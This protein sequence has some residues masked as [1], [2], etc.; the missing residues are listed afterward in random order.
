M[1][2]GVGPS[3]KQR[4]SGAGEAEHADGT[5]HTCFWP[6]TPAHLECGLES[7]CGS[8]GHGGLAEG[9]MCCGCGALGR[10]WRVGQ[11]GVEGWTV[12]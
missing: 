10:T 7:M 12:C 8:A 6:G 3:W 11:V 4:E 1:E 5:L 9:P 2:A